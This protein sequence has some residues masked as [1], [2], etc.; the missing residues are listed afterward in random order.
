ML[1]VATLAV[2]ASPRWLD[3]T[4]AGYALA[5]DGRRE[6]IGVHDTKRGFYLLRT[7][8]CDGAILTLTL[9]HDRNVVTDQG[10]S[11]PEFEPK[12]SDNGSIALVERTLPSLR[13]GKGVVVGDTPNAVRLRLG[14]P[15]RT[16][17][18]APFLDFV[19]EGH[20]REARRT[21]HV[22]RYTFKSG[23]LVEIQFFRDSTKE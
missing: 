19:Y 9:T 1:L 22:Q 20:T 6:M 3:R 21:D 23:R 16:K 4:L 10:F 17:R 13:T 7:T 11:V 2:A 12:H 18:H 8:E 5:V 15:T 14:S